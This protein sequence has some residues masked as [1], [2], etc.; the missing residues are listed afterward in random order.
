MEMRT[1]IYIVLFNTIILH[2]CMFSTYH[3][4]GSLTVTNTFDLVS[5]IIHVSGNL[6]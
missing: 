3:P 6:H 5:F 2:K 1:L 4:S